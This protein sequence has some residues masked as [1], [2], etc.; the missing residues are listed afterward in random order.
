MSRVEG[1]SNDSRAELVEMAYD[2]VMK[3]LGVS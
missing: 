1:S 2:H 3:G